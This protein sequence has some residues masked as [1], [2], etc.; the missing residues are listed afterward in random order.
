MRAVPKELLA[1]L[2]VAFAMFMES[3]DVNIIATSLP[4]MARD[5]GR[6]PVSLQIGVI[7]YVVGL[8]IFIPV[9]GWV[10]DRFGS[11][12]VFQT[13][14]GIFVAGSLLCA[15]STSLETF[16]LA[17]F[18]QGIGGAMMVPVGRIII[19]R[20]VP[21]SSFV[22]AM[23]Y[24]SIPALFGPAAGPVLG[25]FLT[26]YLHWRVIFFINI[27]VGI[28]GIWLAQRHI[29]NSQ[30]PHPGPLDWF[31]FVLSAGGGASFLLG[32][33]LIGGELLPHTTA[34]CLCL[35]GIALLASYA[36]YASKVERP[37]LELRFLSI[38]SFQASV[39]GG[40]LFR[41]GLG[42]LP[43]LLPLYLQEGFGMT[44]FQSG[45]ITCGSAA[46]S[47]IVKW[48]A[49]GLLRRFGFRTVLIYN[50][51][52]S[53]AAIAVCG[54]FIPGTP[55]PLIWII[56]LFSGFFPSLQF[57]SLNS[58]AY[59]DIPTRDVG[60]ATSLASVVQQMSLGLGV[61]VA[62]LVLQMSRFVQGH[63]AYHWSDFWPAFLIIGMFS[64]ASIP[65]TK[66]MPNDAGQEI[67]RGGR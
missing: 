52:F 5:F 21:R 28:A 48:L 9:C 58:L 6:D 64:L 10:A 42:A 7:S 51:G 43:F 49:P 61:A 57:T 45:L 3:M 63:H 55:V 18:I 22:R 2:I 23:N 17:R 12:L 33:S 38:P 34:A 39:A 36:L 20:A 11:R 59:S 25:G 41:L 27:P 16:A 24:L 56:V 32:L 4:D 46:G 67:A 40:S 60:R 15:A 1:P 47:F 26:T 19:F 65:I 8:G 44:A 50:A 53:A 31:G 62:G 30:E 29:R 35:L 37:L 13:A 66:R 54:C 14:I